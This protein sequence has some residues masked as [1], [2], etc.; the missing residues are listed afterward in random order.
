M[1]SQ[2]QDWKAKLSTF[3]STLQILSKETSRRREPALFQ[4]LSDVCQYIQEVEARGHPEFDQLAEGF[5]RLLNSAIDV[6]S[7][8]MEIDFLRPFTITNQTPLLKDQI[9]PEANAGA[10]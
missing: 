4:L 8:K 7:R 5:D 2:T 6:A 9:K 1:T 3:S 10:F